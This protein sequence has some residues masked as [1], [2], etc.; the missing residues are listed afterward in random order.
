L[1]W[2]F[3]FPSLRY[4][5]YI[6]IL[7]IFIITFSQLFNFINCSSKEIK[8]KFIILLSF[9]ILV[10]VSKNIIR[11]NKEFNYSAVDNFKS[12]PFFFVKKIKY[13][14]Q[15][16]NGEKVFKVEG[17]CWAT[18]TPCLRNINKK[19]KRKYNYRFYYNN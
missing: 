6:L 13:K 7:S 3:K 18:P 4:G 11:L 1:I 12:F 10:F 15:Y 5:G 2:F 8:K 17:M 14:E 16:V 9:S 19:I